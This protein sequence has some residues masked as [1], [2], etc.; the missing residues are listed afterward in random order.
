MAWVKRNL[1]FV[2]AL[3][4]GVLVLGGGVFYS[5]AKKGEMEEV[6]SQLEQAASKLDTLIKRKPYPNEDNI[7]AA[8]A[9]QSAQEAKNAAFEA[10]TKLQLTE[11]G[12]KAPTTG[13]IINKLFGK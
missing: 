12:D 5:F 1:Y 11:A 10:K 7:K 9:E 4:A 2:L 8:K 3:V 6:S 13:G